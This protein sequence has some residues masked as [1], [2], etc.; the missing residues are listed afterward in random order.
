LNA[1]SRPYTAKTLARVLPASSFSKT[2][3]K[4]GIGWALPDLDPRGLDDSA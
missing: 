4:D 2:W 1:S 3:M